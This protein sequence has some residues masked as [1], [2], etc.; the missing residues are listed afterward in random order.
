MCDITEVGVY[1]NNVAPNELQP[2]IGSQ[3]HTHN[4][5]VLY[6]EFFYWSIYCSFNMVQSHP[7]L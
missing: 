2:K 1:I 3:L 5:R 4:F 7:Q 6:V